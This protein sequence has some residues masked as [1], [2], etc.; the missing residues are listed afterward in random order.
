M[1]EQNTMP[2]GED[3]AE[4]EVWFDGNSVVDGYVAVFGPLGERL[5]AGQQVI[6]NMEG[7]ALFHATVTMAT[8]MP[9]RDIATVLLGE[10][11]G[12]QFQGG[13]SSC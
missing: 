11:F 2:A 8:E 5:H 3:A 7:E 6:A 13:E 1:A 10:Q 4:V 12:R 9:E